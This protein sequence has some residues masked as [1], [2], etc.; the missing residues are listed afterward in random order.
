MRGTVIVDHGR[1]KHKSADQCHFGKIREGRKKKGIGKTVHFPL[2]LCILVYETQCVGYV[3]IPQVNNTRSDPMLDFSLDAN[4]DLLHSLVG[5]WTL[6]YSLHALTSILQTIRYRIAQQILFRH[7]PQSK[8]VIN[9][10]SPQ[11][12]RL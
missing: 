8:H 9:N 7:G 2:T 1:D 4:Q 11:G 12:Q 3:M 10:V 6:L 5:S